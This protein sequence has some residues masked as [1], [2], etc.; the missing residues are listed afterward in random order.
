[1]ATFE[2]G[3]ALL[4]ANDPAAAAATFCRVLE[5]RPDDPPVLFQLGHAISR[6]GETDLAL[7]LMGQAIARDDGRPEWHTEL[8][9]L[10]ER[11]GLIGDAI[12]AYREARRLAPENRNTELALA[13]LLAG[14]RQLGEAEALVAD[15]L[16]ADPGNAMASRVLGLVALRR[17]DA[18]G[19]TTHLLAALHERPND[20]EGLFLLGTALH[21][22][23][24]LEP[25]VVAYRTALA[26]APDRLEI[27]TNLATALLEQGDLQP[28]LEHAERSVAL[29]P[30]RAGGYLNRANCHRAFENLV[31]ALADYRRAIVL[32]PESPEAWSSLANLLD[33]LDETIPA[34]E[35]HERAV[36]LAPELAQAHWNRSFTLLG[37]GRL[38]EGWDEYEWRF[39]T[40]AARPEP[41]DFSMPRWEGEPIDGQRL[42][43]WREQGIGDELLFATCLPDLIARGAQVTLVA[44]PR[45]T[46]LFA[47]A[48]PTVQVTPDLPEAIAALEPHG[49]HVPVGSLPRHLRRTRDRF[50]TSAPFLIPR[51]DTREAWAVRLATLP[52]GPRIGICWRSGLM[53]PERLRHYSSLTQWGKLFAL[54][55]I[56]WINLQYDQCEAELVEAEARFGVTIHRWADVDL[57]DDLESVVGLLSHLDLVVTAPTAVVALAGAAG[58][59]TWQVDS[60]SEWSV[61]GED[62]NPWLPT[63]R[64][65]WLDRKEG[66]E[67]LLARVAGEVT[68]QVS[69]VHRG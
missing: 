16:A 45:L 55:G 59:P 35:A 67:G 64:M 52:P 41:R 65:A 54:P 18:V 36:A 3:L 14:D 39:Q 40:E 12:D 47:R 15:V 28:A 63:V 29:A 56:Q 9:T 66:W 44:S 22:R 8:G 26:L 37:A 46:S 53:T 13:W 21:A 1:M 31:A 4:D 38:G 42:L 10:L 48:F 58:V 43:V 7:S 5:A 32:E 51:P 57:K 68:A 24:M 25:A 2:E 20:M 23:E 33:D 61:F 27:H 17:G 62:R 34:L 60:G 6:L 19:A 11:R 30:E 49:Y 69:L 50:S